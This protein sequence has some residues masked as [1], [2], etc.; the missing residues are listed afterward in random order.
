MALDADSARLFAANEDVVLQHEIADVLEPNAVF[1]ERLIVFGS[2]AIEHLGGVEGARHATGP[3]L[4]LQQP[5]Q[6]DGENLVWI[7]E[8]AVLIDR[9]QP[10]GIA[11]GHESGLAFLCGRPYPGA[12]ERAAQWAQG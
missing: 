4:A 9:A 6:Q 2:D 10:I 11:V 3:A 12:R 5:T 8:V 1:V 7:D